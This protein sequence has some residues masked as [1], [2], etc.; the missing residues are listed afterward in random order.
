MVGMIFPGFILAGLYIVY[1]LG[2]CIIDPTAGPR[3]PRTDDELA[4]A[5]KL[6]ITMRAMVPPVLMIVAVLGSIMFGWASATEAAALGPFGALLLPIVY[7]RFSL[8][9]FKE[10]LPQPLI[11]TTITMRILHAGSLFTGVCIA[12][13]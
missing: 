5:E 8:P 13:G 2:R 9:I 3:L 10:A 7:R 4:L 1:V 12:A 6:S 11:V